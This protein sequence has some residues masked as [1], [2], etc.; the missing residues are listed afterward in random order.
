MLNTTHYQ[1]NANQNHNE[2]HFAPVRMVAIQKFTNKNH[3]CKDATAGPVSGE[4]EN[5]SQS[6]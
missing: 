6:Y 3:K 2:Y 1:R 4:E 5:A